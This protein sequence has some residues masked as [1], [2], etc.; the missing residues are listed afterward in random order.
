MKK[1]F[2]GLIVFGVIFIAISIQINILNVVPLNGTVANIGIVLVLGMGLMCDRGPGG[3]IG[4]FYGFMQDILFGKTIG[5]YALLYMLI[6]YV[7]GKLGRGFSRDN[8]TTMIVMVGIGT[9][10]F[11]IL[12]L[13]LSKFIYDYDFFNF[14]VLF[15]LLKEAIYNMVI[16]F[17]LFKPISLL[18][19]I[20]NKSKNSYYLL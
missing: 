7:A 11:D 9:I 20:I 18:A 12:F 15:N 10:F 17:I 13:V 3:I 8:K 19:E 5:T 2:I 1:I 4:I 6:G 14:I 16:A